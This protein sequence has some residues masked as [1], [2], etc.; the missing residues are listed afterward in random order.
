MIG[1]GLCDK[2]PRKEQEKNYNSGVSLEYNH[3]KN[4]IIIY[5]Y[6][7]II[8]MKTKTNPRII[9]FIKSIELDTNLINYIDLIIVIKL[10]HFFNIF[11]HNVI[12]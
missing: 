11:D 10:K 9:Y 7:P 2:E 3:F 1:C 12:S 4:S 6:I 5:I 8:R